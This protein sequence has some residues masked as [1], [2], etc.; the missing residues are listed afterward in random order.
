MDEGRNTTLDSPAWQPHG[1]RRG[2]LQGHP[3]DPH[4]GRSRRRRD[5]TTGGRE[6]E[7]VSA[8]LRQNQ[9]W[10]LAQLERVASLRALRRPERRPDA[11]P[12]FCAPGEIVVRRGQEAQTPPVRGLEN[13]LRGQARSAIGDYLPAVTARI[14]KEPGWV[15]VMGQRP[16]SC[17]WS[18][19]TIQRSSG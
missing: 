13:W 4:S 8:F 3:A 2:R 12:M 15:Y 18:S 6:D 14:G 19:R 7:D 1:L 9:T 10:V 16:I 11:M 5:R 17:I